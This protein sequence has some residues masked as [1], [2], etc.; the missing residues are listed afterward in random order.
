M[1]DNQNVHVDKRVG[2]ERLP[3]FDREWREMIELLPESRREVMYAAVREYQL[4]GA[5][6]VG[7]EGA[8]MMAF[9]L[10]RKIVDRRKKRRD[11]RKSKL[12]SN[13]SAPVERQEAADSKAVDKD[14]CS[15]AEKSQSIRCGDN[16]KKCGGPLGGILK[17]REK[18][19]AGKERV[20]R[21]KRRAT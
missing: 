1:K 6:P 21:R 16:K 12:R 9:M 17:A 2:G 4:Y 7:L 3:R 8:E 15:E 11:A 5:E 14:R 20:N 19:L 13:Q 10:I 18:H